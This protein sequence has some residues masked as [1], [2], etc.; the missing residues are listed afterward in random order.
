MAAKMSKMG[1]IKSCFS[2][3]II[4]ANVSFSCDSDSSEGRL[5]PPDSN[6]PAV[7][8]PEEIASGLAIP[9]GLTFLPDGSALVS[10]RNT[11]RIYMVANDR[12]RILVGTVP[13]VSA[14]SE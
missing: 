4:V 12:K 8:T 5:T 11:A 6:S 3:L 7:D 14:S 10:E 2:V 13:G 9:W 1:F